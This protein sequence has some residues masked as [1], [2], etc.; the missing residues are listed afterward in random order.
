M[1]DCQNL[2]RSHQSALISVFDDFRQGHGRYDSFPRAHVA[3][4]QPLHRHFAFHIGLYI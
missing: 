3:L 1:L 4:Y 2:R